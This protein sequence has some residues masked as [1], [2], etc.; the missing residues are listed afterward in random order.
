MLTVSQINKHFDG[1]HAVRDVSF[2]VKEGE[3][4]GLLG[5]NGAGK[6]T[7]LR[8][9]M[10]IF[11]PDSGT[12]TLKGRAIEDSVKEAI[13]YLPEEHGLYRKSKVHDVLLYF[14]G[15]KN[16]SRQDARTRA[17]HW[18]NRFGLSEFARRRCDELSKGMQQKIQFIIAVLHE[19]DLLILDE[20]FSGLDPVNQQLMKEVIGELRKQGR[21]ILFS[22]HQMDQVEKMCERICMIHLGRR[23]LYGK[24]QDVKKEHGHRLVRIDCDGRE[25]LETL[26]V[27]ESVSMNENYV[28]AVPNRGVTSDEILKKILELGEVRHFEVVRASL[29]QI[30]IEQVTGRTGSVTTHDDPKTHGSG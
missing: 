19:P 1:V 8:M 28:E 9:I 30:F 25:K 27:F 7:I 22:A 21:T 29:E 12:I 2:E 11:E 18:L 6:T 20:P 17:D 3:V 24:L 23:V 4:F 10:K 14:A 5:P 16:V 26:G 13:G 15:L